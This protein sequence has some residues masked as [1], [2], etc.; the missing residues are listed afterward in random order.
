MSSKHSLKYFQDHFQPLNRY[1]INLMIYCFIDNVLYS[2]TI[3]CFSSSGII[4]NVRELDDMVEY[5]KGNLNSYLYLP[6]KSVSVCHY[7]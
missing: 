6:H 7:L 1:K 5:V 4:D 3:Y 2:L